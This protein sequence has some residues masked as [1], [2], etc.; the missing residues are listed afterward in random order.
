MFHSAADLLAEEN[1]SEFLRTAAVKRLSETPYGF[2]DKTDEF[3]DKTDISSVMVGGKRKRTSSSN[4]IVE[5]LHQSDARD[6]ADT[7]TRLH[8]HRQEMEMRQRELEVKKMEAETMRMIMM[9]LLK[10]NQ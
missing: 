1:Q 9:E 3:D 10:K 2:D 7:E 8:M 4:A 5:Y 6:R